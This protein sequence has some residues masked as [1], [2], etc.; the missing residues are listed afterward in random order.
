VQWKR[1]F[2][3]RP[4]D[5]EIDEELAS[6]LRMAIQDRIDRGES[7]QQA[8]ASAMREFGRASLVKEDTRAVWISAALERLGQDIRYA[9]RQ[10]R[11]SP[12]F[13]AVAVL[14]LGFGL[15]VNITIFSLISHLFLQPLPV[16]DAG[17]LV[18]L[19]QQRAN[20]EFPHGMSWSDF[21]DYRAELDEFG[22]MLALSY[23]PAHLSFAG[24]TPDRTWIE[25][26]SGNYFSMLGVQPLTGRLFQAGEGEKRGADPVAVLGYDYWNTRLGADPGIVGTTAVINGRSFTVIGVAAKE[27][28]SAQWA[29]AP[30][31]F[32]PATMIPDTFAGTESILESRDSAA[33]KVIAYLR[34]GVSVA[35]ASS[36]VDVVAKRLAREY[37]PEQAGTQAYVL[38]ERLARPDPSVSRF[39]PF[40][41][42]VFSVLA[43]LVLFIA[44]ANVANLMFS[45]ALG[46]HKEIGIRTA[47]GAPR[48][49]LIR[50]LLT[51]SVV[52]GVL[53]GI[54]G[55]LLSFA[56]APLLA[57]FAPSPQDVPIRPDERF[58]WLPL[59]YTM[60]V[61]IAAGAVTGLLPALRATKV[62]VYSVLKGVTSG[63]GRRRS[64]LRSTLVLAQ[65]AVCVLVLVCGGLFVRS[66][67]ELASH[68]LGFETERLL[69][70]SVDLG[71][72]GYGE[73]QGRQFIDQ[74]GEQVQALPG[75]KAAAVASTV[76]FGNYFQTRPVIPA[77]LT[78]P[79]DSKDLE[80][81]LKAGV[82]A[83]DPSYFH[84]LGV[85]LLRGRGFDDQDDASSPRVAV[86]NQ[87]LA[88]RLWPNDDALGKQ[89]RWG[90]ED[91]P[92]EVVGIA[93]NGKY[94][95]LGEAPRAYVYLPAAQSYSSLVTLHVRVDT[96]DPLAMTPPVREVFRGL[97][98]NLPV[99]NVITMDE[100][101]RGSA[102]AF[103]PLRMGAVL[104]GAQGVVAL[105][106][107]MIGIYGVVAYA[108]S[109]QTREIGIRIALGARRLD[110]FHQ[111]SR[112]GLRPTLVGLALGLAAAFGLAR[113]LAVLLYGLNPVSVPVFL[114]V[115][116]LML[117]VA[118]LACWLPARRAARVD[119]IEALRQE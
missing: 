116:A 5:A 20:A 87:T 32:I 112:S 36:A 77:D 69:M 85:T 7:P 56:V 86:V 62:D 96:A 64:F 25:S 41:A 49:R 113:L 67:R 55:L 18:L 81:A 47:I 12:G 27:F 92:I 51:E 118:L 90:P 107:A 95:M 40:A 68:R 3:R 75:V 19:L 88:G 6:H 105:L 29:M 71:L 48:R 70:A 35:E 93:A 57:R 24:R 39:V 108:V 34:D 42:V 63:G 83:V 109:Q 44:C 33:F 101:L 84:T 31:A 78:T 38:P 53:A 28:Q 17:R 11:R 23:R 26:V 54:T 30:A 16:R 1:L 2:G 50:Q 60:V 106:L 119:P 102:F 66:L 22:G 15:A 99:Y 46:R 58:D 65:T 111:V 115:V 97:D 72:Q 98:P 61:S 79:M 10:M 104:A 73:D 8:R 13:T 21:L 117:S 91:E 43:G 110:I 74:L 94:V 4:K 14:T 82:N 9:Y 114:A 59:L 45:R 37:R 52:L 100:H 89:F 80:E 76:P 103:L